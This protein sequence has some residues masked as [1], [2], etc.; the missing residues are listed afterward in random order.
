MLPKYRRLVER[1]AQAG[2]LKVI[3]GTDTLGVGVNVPIRTVLFTAL[4][5]YDGRRTRLLRAREFH[6]IAGRAGRAGFDTIGYV[7]AQAPDHVIENEKGPGQDRGRPEEAAQGTSARSRR[8]A[9]STGASDLREADRGR[10]RAAGLPLPGHARDA[11]LGD[12]PAGQRLRGDAQAADRQ[13]RA[14]R[15]PAQAHPP[16]DRDLPLAAGRGRGRAP[17]PSGRDRPHRPPH[18]RPAAGLRHEPGAVHLRPGRL[19]PARPDRPR[20]TPST[21]SPS[22]SPSSTTRGRSWSRRRR[23]HAARRSR[24]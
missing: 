5:K 1:L 10:A 16:R 11:A 3:C 6:Q 4:S 2:L 15:Q 21:C 7:V 24:R 23:R 22:S 14:A 19:R 12:R 20:P 8:R 17:G 13:P 18:R 9:S